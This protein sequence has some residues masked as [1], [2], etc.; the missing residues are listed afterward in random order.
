[1]YAPRAFVSM[2][3]VL[4]VF[5]LAIYWSTGSFFTTVWQTV[6]CAVILQI[7]YFIGVLY[8]VRREKEK[9]EREGAQ[10]EAGPVAKARG[11]NL[12]ADAA[13]NLKTTDR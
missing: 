6:A 7:G 3:A 1:M 11:E 5:A 8:L 12:P 10:G 13:A 4:L 2:I 9:R